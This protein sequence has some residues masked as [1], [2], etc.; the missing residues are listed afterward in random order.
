MMIIVQGVRQKVTEC[1]F[2]ALP[3]PQ[4]PGQ[5][6]LETKP[7]DWSR[8]VMAGLW[9]VYVAM[10]VALYWPLLTGKLPGFRDGFHFYY[11]LEVWLE[12]ERL[13]GN[14]LPQFNPFDGTGSNLVGEGTTGLLYPGRVLYWIPGMSVAQRMGLF[15]LLHNLLAGM[16]AYAAARWN[17]CSRQAAYMAAF[18]YSL[19]CPVFFQQ[20]NTIFLVGAAWSGWALG[21]CW[22]IARSAWSCPIDERA[23]CPSEITCWAAWILATSM[24]MLG[25]DPQAAVH[26]SL[27]MCLALLYAAVARPSLPG[28]LKMLGKFVSSQLIVVG[29]TAVFWLPVLLWASHS[30]RGLASDPWVIDPNR[31]ENLEELLVQMQGTGTTDPPATDSGTI[32]H[33]NKTVYAFSVAPWHLLTMVWS[34][35]T[36]SIAPENSRWMTMFSAEPRMWIPSLAIGMIPTLLA[37]STWKLRKHQSGLQWLWLGAAFT[38]LAMLGNYAPMWMLR[39]ALHW[40]SIDT[41]SLPPNEVGGVYWLLTWVVPGYGAFRYPAKWSV[42]FALCMCLMSA[43]GTDRAVLRRV[44]LKRM[45]LVI[46]IASGCVLIPMLFLNQWDVTAALANQRRLQTMD[47]WLGRFRADAALKI[48]SASLAT[49]AALSVALFALHNKRPGQLQLGLIA[50]MIL[51]LGYAAT[52]WIAPVDP[53]H[54]GLPSEASVIAARPVENIERLWSPVHRASIGVWLQKSSQG[55]DGSLSNSEKQC[56]YQWQM[57]LGKLHLLQ[58]GM[59]SVNATFT[60]RP[61]AMAVFFQSLPSYRPAIRPVRRPARSPGIPGGLRYLANHRQF[62]VTRDHEDP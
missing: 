2:A 18:A 8:A 47:P 23:N 29:L 6:E 11:P 35:I 17:G 5:I 61:A 52:H 7:I 58:P 31:K 20:F 1:R 49:C 56:A 39:N 45:A 10:L 44:F 32:I 48:I 33:Q 55:H 59:G 41:K 37:L 34:T 14:W 28:V 46:L 40:F 30:Q 9:L 62:S 16:G 4:A 27:L 25:G 43:V 42:L 24:M 38:G 21:A 13:A 19:S 26:S 60:M 12:A 57:R 36:G 54:I 50:L 3:M 15:L 51:D 53:L 22:L